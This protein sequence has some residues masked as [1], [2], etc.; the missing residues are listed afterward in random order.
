MDNFWM[1]VKKIYL[2]SIHLFVVEWVVLIVFS[3][4]LYHLQTFL[5]LMG[6]WLRNLPFQNTTLW[7][8]FGT[9]SFRPCRT[10]RRFPRLVVQLHIWTQ[11]CGL[12]QEFF[13][14]P[15]C[16]MGQLCCLLFFAQFPQA[17]TI[18]CRVLW[19]WTFW[20]LR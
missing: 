11:I 19:I 15:T 1:R 12:L 17:K 10:V 13:G 3:T 16:Y 14:V 2:L 5:V 18:V 6:T 9:K 7:S 4:L 20:H 8:G